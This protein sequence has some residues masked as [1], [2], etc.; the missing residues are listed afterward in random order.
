M[1]HSCRL[2]QFIYL[3][4][5]TWLLS[6]WIT[7]RQ[8]LNGPEAIQRHVVTRTLEIWYSNIF[9]EPSEPEFFSLTPRIYEDKYHFY[10]CGLYMDHMAV[11][12]LILILIAIHAG[13]KR[14]M[15]VSKTRPFIKIQPSDQV[16]EF[17]V[18]WLTK[19]EVHDYIFVA[20]V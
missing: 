17:E 6:P 4:W 3:K 14:E 18:F 16:S 7:F 15:G 20:F 2:S 13:T 8:E 19:D 11:V 1:L 9:S 10:I 12:W 5:L